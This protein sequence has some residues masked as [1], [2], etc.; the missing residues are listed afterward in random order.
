MCAKGARSLTAAKLAERLGFNPA[1]YNLDGG[2]SGWVKAGFRSSTAE[3]LDRE[4]PGVARG[5]CVVPP[6]AARASACTALRLARGAAVTRCPVWPC[7]RSAPSP[8]FPCSPLRAPAAPRLPRP[9]RLPCPPAL[10]GRE[11]GARRAL[12]TRDGPATPGLGRAQQRAR[13]GPP[14]RARPVLAGARRLPG[15]RARGPGDLDL[16]PGVE[17]QK[18]AAYRTA[19]VELQKRRETEKDPAVA[20]DLQILLDAADRAV[21]SSELEEKHSVTYVN[22]TGLVFEG[23]SNSAGRP[24]TAGAALRPAR[25]SGAMPASSRATC[26]SPSRRMARLLQDLEKPGLLAPP[27]MEIERHPRHE[28]P[29]AGG[30]R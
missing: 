15:S 25:A 11:H 18:R 12:G 27:R 24:G 26:P 5:A 22:V 30:H 28:R 1:L 23:I 29:C 16:S 2:T 17:A 21:R 3:L 10:G 4:H 14:R 8:S 9:R 6:I 7:A 19:I 13:E 20:E